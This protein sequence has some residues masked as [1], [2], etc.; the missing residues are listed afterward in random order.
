MSH[1]SYPVLA[2]ILVLAMFPLFAGCVSTGVGDTFYGNNSVIVNI[3]HAGEPADVSV[4][5]TIY[6]IANLTQ[7][8]YSVVS[9]PAMLVNGEN[10]V[11]VPVLLEPGAYKL[12]V[13]VLGNGDRKTAVIRDIVV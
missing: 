11:A 9:A 8:K 6:H 1:A 4:Q 2:G 10:T 13:Y 3:T 5:V 7:E 12:Y